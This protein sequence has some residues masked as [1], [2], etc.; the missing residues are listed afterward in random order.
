M[1]SGADRH[2][3]RR[4]RPDSDRHRAGNRS[5]SRDRRRYSRSPS[6]RPRSPPSGSRVSRSRSRSPL[7]SSSARHDDRITRSHSDVNSRAAPKQYK[8]LKKSS[9]SSRTSSS[10]EEKAPVAVNLSHFDLS[11]TV[12]AKQERNDAPYIPQPKVRHNNRMFAHHA[13]QLKTVSQ[14]QVQEL[15]QSYE[16][17]RRPEHTYMIEVVLNDRLGKKVDS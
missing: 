12:L 16:Q 17:Q 14:Q 2:F 15:Q 9:E 3:D 5:R 4:S 10:T 1:S 11:S 13:V 8:W 6:R 7:H